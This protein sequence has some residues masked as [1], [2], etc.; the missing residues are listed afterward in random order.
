MRKRSKYVGQT[1][2]GG[3]RCTAIYLA[4]NYGGGTKHNAYRYKL[5]RVTSDG[6][7]DKIMSVSGS[8][9]RQIAVGI[10]TA[11]SVL[12]YKEKSTRQIN[13]ITYKFI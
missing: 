13:E 1:F 6:K 8:T 12:D 2:A 9:M 11:E 4:N 5:V 7:C 10:K 3:W